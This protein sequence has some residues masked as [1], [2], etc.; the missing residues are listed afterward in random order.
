MT[1]LMVKPWFHFLSYEF[2]IFISLN[3]Q[4]YIYLFIYLLL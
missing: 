1:T 2:K 4:K 3:N